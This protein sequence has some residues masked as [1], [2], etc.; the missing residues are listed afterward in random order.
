LSKIIYLD[1]SGDLGFN[2]TAPYRTGGSSRYLTVASLCVPSA[3]SH[4]PKRIIKDLYDKF[5]WSPS[6]EKKWVDMK[7]AARIAFAIAVHAMCTAHP[8][9]HL[10]VITVKKENVAQ[11]IRKDPNKLYNY[12]IRLSILDCMATSDAVVMVPDPRSIK[13]ES[14]KSLHDYLQIEL[15]FSKRVKTELSSRPVDSKNCKGIQFADMLSGLVQTRFEDKYF[16]H[17]KHC[18]HFL[19]LKRLFFGA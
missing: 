14:G 7:P 4:I 9:I 19:R 18:V 8:D 5:G 11:H 6:N 16:E 12:M 17:I 3:K 10:H 13:V 1:E 15:W 2:F